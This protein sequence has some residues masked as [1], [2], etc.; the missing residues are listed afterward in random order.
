M[1]TQNFISKMHEYERNENRQPV[2]DHKNRTKDLTRA[3]PK[4]IRFPDLLQTYTPIYFF[5][6]VTRLGELS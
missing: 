2:T 4:D 5:P 3:L 1:Q 6:I